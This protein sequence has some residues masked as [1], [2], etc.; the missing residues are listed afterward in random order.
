[1]I[2]LKHLP[3]Q[4]P[5]EKILL[6]LRRH[7]LAP[8]KLIFFML[9][10]AAVP[11][12]AYFVISIGMP[13]FFTHPIFYPISVLAASFYLLSVWIFAFQEYIDYYLDT[14]IV[15]NWRIINIEQKGLFSRTSSSLHLAEVQDV[16]SNITGVVKTFL[17]YG[18]VFIQTAGEK[19]RFEF[20]D[21]H[22]PEEVKSQIIRFADQAKISLQ[23]S[24]ETK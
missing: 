11:F 13:N 12:G 9:V 8:L 20:K 19:H 24:D 17:N 16:T 23:N 14:W 2:D 3:N 4:K 22:N 1:M 18:D 5:D 21:I 15:T 6:F 7:W 10:A